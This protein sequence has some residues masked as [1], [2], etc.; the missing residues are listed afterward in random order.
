MDAETGTAQTSY[1]CCDKAERDETEGSWTRREC[2][3]TQQRS[4]R[5]STPARCTSRQASA[6]PTKRLQWLHSLS[7]H[8]PNPQTT[9]AAKVREEMSAADET[10]QNYDNLANNSSTSRRTV[11]NKQTLRSKK[12]VHTPQRG[13]KG[14]N[15]EDAGSQTDKVDVAQGAD[16]VRSEDT[17]VDPALGPHPKL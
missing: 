14:Q 2:Q 4:S 13:I 7:D 6:K 17:G 5:H 11:R 12:H 16:I 8:D 10:L 9:P 15:R 3:S 1:A